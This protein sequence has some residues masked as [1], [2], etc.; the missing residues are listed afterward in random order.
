MPPIF[1][2]FDPNHYLLTFKNIPC[3]APFNGTFITVAMNADAYEA[4]P[5]AGGDVVRVR[6][7]NSTGLVTWTAMAESPTNDQLSV[8]QRQDRLLN[9]GYGPL[10]LKHTNGLTVVQAENAWIKKMPQLDVGDTAVGREWVFE[11]AILDM[12]VGG[13]V[14]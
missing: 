6:S 7:R 3:L 13:A 2:T 11:C 9:N 14:V 12:Y 8:I 5:G 4:V 1:K 10:L